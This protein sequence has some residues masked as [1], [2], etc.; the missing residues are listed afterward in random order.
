[1]GDGVGIFAA[2]Y[3]EL[4]VGIFGELGERVSIGYG[5]GLGGSVRSCGFPRRGR[6]GWTLVLEWC[7]LVEAMGTYW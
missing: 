7:V 6:G 2:D 4:L 1:M 3:G 5:G